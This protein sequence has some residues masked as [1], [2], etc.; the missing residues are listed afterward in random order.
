ML[1]FHVLLRAVAFLPPA[2]PVSWCLLR[3]FSI[4][5]CSLAPHAH[6]LTEAVLLPQLPLEA[7]V[8]LPAAS[9]LFLARG[10]TLLASHSWNCCRKMRRNRYEKLKPTEAREKKLEALADQL[11]QDWMRVDGSGEKKEYMPSQ[12]SLLKPGYN[13]LKTCRRI[14]RFAFSLSLYK[15]SPHPLRNKGTRGDIFSYLNVEGNACTWWLEHHSSI[16]CYKLYT[17]GKLPSIAHLLSF[18]L[19]A[20]I[21]FQWIQLS[22]TCEPLMP[23][24]PKP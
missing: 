22:A 4:P 5:P 16:H 10:I 14:F 24:D 15:V 12:V 7:H 3:A 8:A 23:I 6:A 9:V 2:V 18:A 21:N 13:I 17:H 1:F 11:L 19:R 20:N